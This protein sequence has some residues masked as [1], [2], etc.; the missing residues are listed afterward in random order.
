MAKSTSMIA[1][2]VTMPI[3]ISMPIQTGMVSCLPVSSSAAMA[4]P[5]DS[6]S[7]NRMVIGC[8]KRAEQHDQHRIDHHQ[9]GAHGAGEAVGQFLQALGVA[10]L[11]DADALGQALHHRQRVDVA[12][13]ASPSAALPTRSAATVGLAFAVIAA[14]AGRALA[15]A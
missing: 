1:F 9:A 4:P 13:V 8:R 15:Q 2:L 5:I 6:G 11:L 7:E 12:S 10:G 3:S 14:D